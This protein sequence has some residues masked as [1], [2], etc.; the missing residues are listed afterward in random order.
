PPKLGDGRHVGGGR[1]L[2]LERRHENGC[3]TQFIRLPFHPAFS[4]TDVPGNSR[5]LVTAF[6]EPCGE[7]RD[8]ERRAADVQARDDTEDADRLFRH[9]GRLENPTVARSSALPTTR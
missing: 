7:L 6:V 5:R 3:H 2:T 9:R 4:L 8:V 1:D